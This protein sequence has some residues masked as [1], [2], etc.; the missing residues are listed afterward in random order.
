MSSRRELL[1]ELLAE[2]PNDGE[3]LYSLGM[4]SVSEENDIQ[5]I[6][7]FRKALEAD[8]GHVASYLQLGQALVRHGEEG[9]AREIYTQGMEAARKAQNHHAFSE[10]SGFRDTLG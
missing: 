4:E 6:A 10:L 5:A 8:P 9:E 7:E 2:T 3:L 1:M